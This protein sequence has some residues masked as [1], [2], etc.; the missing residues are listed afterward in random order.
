MSFAAT[1]AAVSMPGTLRRIPCP[2]LNPSEAL[3]AAG[4]IGSSPTFC[5]MPPEVKLMRL[6]VGLEA[7]ALV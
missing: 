6:P 4:L 1:A 3:K 5:G 2:W 7:S